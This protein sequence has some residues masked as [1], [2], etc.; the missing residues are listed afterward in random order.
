[1]IAES[2]PPYVPVRAGR[3]ASTYQ[4]AEVYAD[5]DECGRLLGVLFLGPVD[6]PRLIEA[7]VTRGERTG[8]KLAS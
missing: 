6:H 3:I 5:Y 2:D 1:M 7:L 8:R 4:H